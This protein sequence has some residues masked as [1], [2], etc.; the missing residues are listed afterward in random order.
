MFNTSSSVN[1]KRIAKNTLFLYLR[2]L[3]VMGIGLYTVRAILHC[4]VLLTM[5]F[6]ML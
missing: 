6:I 1:N 2:M 4:W 3:V 5:V